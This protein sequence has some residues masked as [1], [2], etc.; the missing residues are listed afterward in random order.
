MLAIILDRVS[1]ILVLSTISCSLSGRYWRI[2]YSV[3]LL[4]SLSYGYRGIWHS[5]HLWFQLICFEQIL[6]AVSWSWS[7]LIHIA[8]QPIRLFG[9]SPMLDLLIQTW[10]FLYQLTRAAIWVKVL[11]SSA[12]VQFSISKIVGWHQLFFRI[13]SLSK[14]QSPM[15]SLMHHKNRELV[16]F[17]LQYVSVQKW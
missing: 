8:N 16:E 3:G 11:A 10:D 17:H 14:W 15:L 7:N 12:L 2:P 9:Y 6:I 13:M 4:N 5:S 1:A